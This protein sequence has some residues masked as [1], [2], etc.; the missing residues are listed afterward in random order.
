LYLKGYWQYVES[1]SVDAGNVYY[2][3]LKHGYLQDPDPCLA[4]KVADV[5]GARGVVERRFADFDTFRAHQGDQGLA[6]ELDALIVVVSEPP[7][8]ESYVPVYLFDP[9]RLVLARVIDGYHRLFL[10]RLFGLKRLRCTITEE[11]ENQLG[12]LQGGIDRFV[13]DGAKLSMSGWCSSETETVN[14]IEVTYGGETLT[15]TPL[16]SSARANEAGPIRSTFDFQC[17]CT[18]PTDRVLDLSL[19]AWSSLAR[20]PVG[21]LPVRYA[22]VPMDTGGNP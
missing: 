21:K 7:P 10:A 19:I 5:S 9:H 6:E 3:Y 17:P 15:W 16:A 1:R 22:V 2:Q 12:I 14:A 18:L 11:R 13:V 20:P 4:L 8:A